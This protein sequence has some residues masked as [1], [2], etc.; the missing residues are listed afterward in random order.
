VF[1]IKPIWV[2]T[3]TALLVSLIVG[4]ASCTTTELK[5]NY[6]V[7][8]ITRRKARKI[9]PSPQEVAWKRVLA[10]AQD[11]TILPG[12]NSPPKPWLILESSMAGKKKY[13]V[14]DRENQ[15]VDVGYLMVNQRS[16]PIVVDGII[17]F[18]YDQKIG[19]WDTKNKVFKLQ[20][21]PTKFSEMIVD[22]GKYYLESERNE[23]FDCKVE[24]IDVQTGDVKEIINSNTNLDYN[25]DLKDRLRYVEKDTIWSVWSHSTNSYLSAYYQQYSLKTGNLL[26]KVTLEENYYDGDSKSRVINITVNVKKK[27][28]NYNTRQLYL[29]ECPLDYTQCPPKESEEAAKLSLAARKEI[30]KT[31]P[32][33]VN[34]NIF[35]DRYE[36]LQCGNFRY[37]RVRSPGKAAKEEITFNGEPL[38]GYEKAIVTSINCIQ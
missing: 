38:L 33:L 14:L 6:V 5:E 13:E 3:F 20:E 28:P 9:T 34:K 26:K 32:F 23:K 15:P 11:G 10:A 7:R 31:V 25:C 18:I 1:A 16:S 36:K 29:Y 35:A 19:F 21:N 2:V 8:V 27:E 24:E 17:Y 22:K 4:I 12:Q 30:E 37:H